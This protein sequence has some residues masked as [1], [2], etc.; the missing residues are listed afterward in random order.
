MEVLLLRGGD[1]RPD[2]GNDLVL[3]ANSYVITADQAIREQ[4]AFS[5]PPLEAIRVRFT[6]AGTTDSSEHRIAKVLFSSPP[7]ELDVSVCR[8]DPP[9]VGI[10]PLRLAAALPRTPSPVHLIGHPCGGSLQ[11]SLSG[12]LIDRDDHRL[13]Y[14]TA[15]EAGSS[16][17]PVFN[18][19]WQVIG[20]HHAGGARLPRLHG[21]GT[22]AANEGISILAIVKALQNRI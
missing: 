10:K 12:R 7:D 20:I 2:W 9:A 13:H 17:S 22:Y 21:S 6:A 3:M 19:D 1:L 8:L 11:L 14:T 15:T 5:V 16:G 4:L 18:G